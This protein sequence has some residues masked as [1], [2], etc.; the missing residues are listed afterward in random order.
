[1]TINSILMRG[2]NTSEW[3]EAKE[4]EMKSMNTN[5]VWETEAVP[6]GAKIV[7]CKGSTRWNVTPKGI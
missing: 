7:G 6:N 1:M 3:Q 4:I 5:K 2:V